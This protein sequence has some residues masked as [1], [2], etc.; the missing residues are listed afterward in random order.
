MNDALKMQISAYV[1]GELPENES[2][3]LIRRLSQDVVLRQQVARYLEIGR[4]IRNDRTVPGIDE[5]RGRISS[6]LGEE[7]AEPAPSDA[8]AAPRF[9][10]P[11]AGLAVAASVAVLVLF[12][13]PQM[14]GG[15]TDAEIEAT[16]GND[17]NVTFPTEMPSETIVSEE[18]AEMHRVHAQSA[19]NFAPN[20]D[21]G[22]LVTLELTEEY[23]QVEPDGHLLRAED[24]DEDGDE[25]GAAAEAG[26]DGDN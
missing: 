13:L 24:D 12:G 19:P 22:R 17:P 25:T 2:E 21:M 9:L 20:G 23:V 10:K 11:L 16:A 8:E 3:L 5:L 4:L 6:A 14:N 7:A 15:P 26:G 1:D 18:L